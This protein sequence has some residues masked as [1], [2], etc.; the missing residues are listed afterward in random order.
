MTYQDPKAAIEDRVQDLLSQMTLPEKLAQMHALWLVLS[1]DGAHKMRPDASNDFSGGDPEKVKTLFAHGLGQ[2]TR[3]LGTFGVDPAAGVRA[4]NR[5]QKDIIE[6]TRL[7]IPVMSHEECLS[8][9]MAQGATLFPTPLSMAG[10]WNPDLIEKVGAAIGAECQSIGAHQGLAPVLDVSR[11]ARWGRTEECFAEDPYLTGVF[12]TRYVRGLQGA[13]R[14]FLATLK[15]YVGHSASEGGRNHAPVHLGPRE[16]AD[17]FML[18]FEM[19]VKGADAASIMPAYHD[20]DGEP[21]HASYRLLTEVLRD[22]WGFDGLIVADYIGVTLLETHHAIAADKGEAAAIAFKAGLDV[23]LPSNECTPHLETALSRGQINMDDINEVVRR[24]LTEKFRIGLFERPYADEGAITLRTPEALALAR[25]VATQGTTLLENN[26]I[27]PLG[28]TAKLA[29]IGPTADDPLALLGD[30]AFPVH[31]INSD[32]TTDTDNVITPLAGLRAAL[33][34]DRVTFAQ[35]CYILETRGSGAPVF[36]GDMADHESIKRN[37]PVSDRIDLIADAVVAAKAADVAVL[38]LG[39]LSGIFQTG[40]VGEGSDVD[41]LALP[42]VQQQLLDAVLDTGTPVIVVLSSGRPYNLGGREKDLAAYVMT[43]F[44]GEQGGHALAD[45]LT[46]AAEPSG[47]LTI[48]TPRSAGACPYHYNHKFKSAGT[49]IARHFGSDYPFGHGL[50]Y[51][52]FE[53]SDITLASAEVPNEGG[54]IEVAVTLTNTGDRT[55]VEVVQLYTRDCMASLVRPIKE[56]KAFARVSL[57]AGA[58]AKVTF[59]VPTDMLNFTGR[60]DRRIVEPGGFDVMIGASSDDIR[61]TANVDVVGAVRELPQ[62]WRME[63]DANI[64]ML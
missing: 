11:D 40:T 23:E 22:Q 35:G 20:I 16:L 25:E 26:G 51:T 27:L 32:A 56:L 9:L 24:I 14:K 8:G 12:A 59:H 63:S 15:H 52:S 60:N 49:P 38:C 6:G 3:P 57:A 1:E 33:G 10:T 28:D 62:N 39:D 4:L 30:Y 46:G 42:G 17:D 54:T 41:T 44:S 5:F 64:T 48:S 37:S 2:I 7:G 45:V 58:S 43:H 53:Y 50:S 47:R 31:L 21:L 18:P 55:G 19:A 36:P 13:D 34:Q 61:L 29:V